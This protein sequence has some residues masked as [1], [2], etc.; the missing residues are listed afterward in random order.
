VRFGDGDGHG[1][2]SEKRFDRVAGIGRLHGGW[3]FVL[4]VI[5]TSL[6]AQ[7]Q[8]GIEKEDVGRGEAAISFGRGL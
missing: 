4:G 8:G 5:E 2:T 3:V 7:L 6:V 1:L